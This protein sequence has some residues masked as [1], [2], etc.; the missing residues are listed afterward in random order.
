M[1]KEALEYIVGLDK[2][3][4][5]EAN[6]REYQREPLTLMSEPVLDDP[7]RVS[8]LDAVV[9]FLY[10][11]TDDVLTE[12]GI[13]IHVKD[14]HRIEVCGEANYDKERNNY[15]IAEALCPEPIYYGKYYD[16]EDFNILLQSRF[17]DNEHK[18]RL[19]QLTGNVKDEAVKQIGDDG[20][21]Q[22]VTVKTGV[23]TVAD[24]YV[25]NPVTLMP[26]R[27]FFEIDQPASPFIFR[28]QSGPACALFEADGGAWQQEAMQRIAIYLGQKL[29]EMLDEDVLPKI[30]I[31]A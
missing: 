26:R 21:S 18:A 8:T 12:D 9:D 5:I 22:A 11:N 14:Y 27:T 30:K 3:S 13:I 31:I 17:E 24:V 15:L 1:I 25:P 29:S 6:G 19:L 4:V 10:G 7:F 2:P 16:A 28:M 23:A 20:V